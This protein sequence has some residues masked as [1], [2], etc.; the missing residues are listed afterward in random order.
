MNYTNQIERIKAK[1]QQLKG[2]DYKREVFGA[3]THQYKLN[4]CLSMSVVRAF[5]TKYSI[6][7]PA[8]YVAFMTQVGNGGAGPFY[9]LVPFE[10]CL[11]SDLDF[12]NNASLLNPTKPFPYSSAWNIDFTDSE[13]DDEKYEKLTEEYF[14]D[15]HIT[16]WIQVANYGCGVHLGLI[17]NGPSYGIIWSDDRGNDEGL[18]PFT[19]FSNEVPISFLDWYERW[20]D[21][22]LKEKPM[23]KPF[24]KI[25]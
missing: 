8:D 2:N 21:K 23:A 3:E 12:Q 13:D 4:P 16:G 7:L 6:T 9:G 20:L 25:W 19:G 10:A 18:H 11:L 17:V 14:D 22:G 1:L 5:E 15:N 24:W